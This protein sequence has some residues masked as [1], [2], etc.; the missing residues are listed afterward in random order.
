MLLCGGDNTTVCVEEFYCVM[1]TILLLGLVSLGRL[2]LGV[3]K[4]MLHVENLAPTILN[5]MAVNYFGRQP[6]RRLG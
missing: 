4:G 3:S 6:A 1:V 2:W 5:I